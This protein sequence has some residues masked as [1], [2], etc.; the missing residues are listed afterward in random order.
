MKM[1]EP[2][3]ESVIA[4]KMIDHLKKKIQHSIAQ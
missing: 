3:R 1:E 2:L 4:S